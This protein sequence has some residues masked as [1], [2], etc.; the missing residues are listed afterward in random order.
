MQG[1][2]GTAS[3]LGPDW[4]IFKIFCQKVK[5]CKFPLKGQF[6]LGLDRGLSAMHVKSRGPM[7]ECWK[8]IVTFFCKVTVSFACTFIRAKA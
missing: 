6:L 8:F 7:A 2:H 1:F 4:Y 3:K 5:V